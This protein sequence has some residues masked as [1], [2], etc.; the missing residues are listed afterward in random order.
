MHRDI[1]RNNL[2]YRALDGNI[3]GVLNDFDLSV[4]R[5]EEPLSPS[6]QRTGEEPYMAVDLLAA[7]PPPPHLYRFD[8]E[9]LYY[10]LAYIICQYHEGKKLENPPFDAWDH[11]PK[12]SLRTQKRVFL[13]EPMTV[14][15]TT[16]FLALRR[17]LLRAR[18]LL[19]VR[20]K[21]I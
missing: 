3:Y 14:P 2:M 19:V 13:A 21:C 8:L 16:N 12:G 4:L 6:K 10:V 17:T 7:G 15:L 1:S 20:C 5:D 11:L 9:Y 18:T